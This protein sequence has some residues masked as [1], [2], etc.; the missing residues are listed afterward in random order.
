MRDFHQSDAD[1]MYYEELAQGVKHYKETDGGRED[2]GEV[3][4]RYAE[5]Y[6]KQYGAECELQANIRSVKNLMENLKFSVE[7]ALNALGIQGNDRV[8]ILK[9]LQK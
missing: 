5:K 4:Q 3:V 9:E 6:A 1:N 2:M 8:A 7:Q